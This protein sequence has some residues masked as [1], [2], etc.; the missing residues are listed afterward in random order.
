MP[1]V[2]ID[3]VDIAYVEEGEG[4]AVLLVH[5]FASTKEVNWVNTGWMKTLADAGYRAVALDNRGHGAS[6]RFH[7][8][9]R[10]SLEKMAGDVIGLADYLSLDHPHLV[11]YSMG[12]RIS[13]WL[14]VHHGNAFGD[15]VLA[16]NGIS[17]I[18]GSGDWNPVREALLAEDVATI[19]DA[20]GL[21]FRKFADQ[22]GSDRIALAECVTAVRQL[23]TEQD[24]RAITNR[25]L[26]AIGTEDDIAGSGQPI[27]DLLARGKLLEIPG[28]DHMRAVGDRVFK[29]GVVDFLDR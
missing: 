29:Q 15:V 7:A 28:R 1:V 26:V 9:E 8:A 14:A 22:T 21:A 13:A 19:R 3:D 20:R 16:G 5:G 12:A 23:F 4:P 25:V 11:G 17:M 6:T 27:V 10:Y 18:E 24:F 2:R